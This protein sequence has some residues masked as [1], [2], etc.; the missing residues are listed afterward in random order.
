MNEDQ[1]LEMAACK[2]FLF[3]LPPERLQAASEA[4]S[5]IFARTDHQLLRDHLN[6]V[7][8]YAEYRGLH[9]KDNA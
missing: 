3:M 9:L 5:G 6:R 1:R 7:A 2:Q 4:L 8:G